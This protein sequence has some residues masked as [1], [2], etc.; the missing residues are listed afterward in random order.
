MSSL[1][2]RFTDAALL[3]SVV[4]GGYALYGKIAEARE[5]RAAKREEAAAGAEAADATGRH[6]VRVAETSMVP[7]LMERIE[8]LEEREQTERR[9]C[10]RQ[11][12]DLHRI[13]GEQA[14]ALVDR[15]RQIMA[16]RVE[17]DE[18][19]GECADATIAAADAAHR[20]DVLAA[21]MREM[22]AALAT[23]RA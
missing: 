19:R 6:A 11:L 17:L 15:D 3:G 22:R 4:T 2:E 14:L 23:G 10:A 8:Q 7:Q 5:A 9:E 16:L 18:V 1:F 20:C 12:A 21:E 13:N